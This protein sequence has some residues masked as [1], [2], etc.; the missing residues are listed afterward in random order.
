MEKLSKLYIAE[1]PD[2]AKAIAGY[3]WPDGKYTKKPGY[4]EKNGIGV[5]WAF[6]HILGLAEP[7]AY[8]EEYK[9]WKNY[10]IIPKNFILRPLADK[11]KQFTVIKNLLKNTVEVIHAGDP[12]REGQLLIDEIL[13]YCGYKGK[14]SRLHLNAKD[15]AS[16][17]RGF[18]S[19]HDNAKNR[20]VYY[21]GLAREEA[22][23]LIGM[24]LTRVYSVCFRNQHP[25][26]SNGVWRIGRV[27]VPTLALVVNREKEIKNFKKQKYYILKARFAK[28]DSTFTTVLRPSENIPTADGKITD[29]AI[30]DAIAAKIK[31]ADAVVTKMEKKKGSQNPP[32]PYS[33]DTLQ[34]EAS[35]KLKLSPADTLAI[36]QKLYDDKLVSYPRSDCNYL[37]EEQ[38]KDAPKI[39][40]N[41]AAYGIPDVTKANRTIVSQCWNNKKIT[42]HHA[43][44]PTR[45]MPDKE[46][47]SANEDKVYRL[48]AD[49][50]MLQFFAPCEFETTKFS[51]SIAGEIM[52]GS[53]KVILA[54]GYRIITGWNDDKGEKDDGEIQNAV[55]PDIT[56]G[57]NIGKPGAVIVTEKISKPPKRFT[58]GTI[59]KAMTNIWRF[60]APDNQYREK[61]KEIKGIG[62]PATRADIIEKLCAKELKGKA[63]IPCIDIVKNELVPT[64]FGTMIIEH[65]DQSL[66]LPDS[67]AIMELKLAEI[68]SG[69]YNPSKFIDEII[70]TVMDNI[71]FA[72]HHQF[73]ADTSQPTFDCP[74][75]QKYQ[76]VRRY[77]QSNKS[78]FWICSDQE[79]KHPLT[80]QTVYYNDNTGTPIIGKCT[81]GTIMLRRRG[82]FGDFWVCPKCSKSYNDKNGKPDFSPKTKKSFPK[83]RGK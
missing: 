12:D 9:Y 67:T 16:L 78:Y 1:K 42:A 31:P 35:D 60:L 76:L 66:S 13:V 79:C 14:V 48:I 33:L 74:I 39:L 19:I 77:S 22:D 59:L 8:G 32:L 34:V 6:G 25:A 62:T 43:I 2:M 68:E 56:E 58:K 49:R 55:L 37:P 75:C 5:T 53:G 28:K 44:I 11:V 41:L 64:E 40:D 21:A 51:I 61:L 63:Q 71:Y 10:P 15:D 3:L 80:Q 69:K 72:E 83:K 50:Y 4:Y 70:N 29:K 24:N 57:E 30:M 52:E 7:E 54:P 65:T 46:K 38:I 82:K 26:N 36:V 73:P 81:D 23:W 20:Y 18:D 27:V 17:K 45:V 47:L